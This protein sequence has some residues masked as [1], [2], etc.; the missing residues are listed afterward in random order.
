[1]EHACKHLYYVLAARGLVGGCPWAADITSG[2]VQ[3]L[4][5]RG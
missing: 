3:I 5:Y 4:A 1:M 2:G